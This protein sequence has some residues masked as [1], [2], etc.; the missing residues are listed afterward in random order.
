MQRI[1]NSLFLPP[2]RHRPTHRPRS[3]IASNPCCGTQHGGIFLPPPP[4]ASTFSLHPLFNLLDLGS[5]LL[6]LLHFSALRPFCVCK[7]LVWSRQ[8]EDQKHTLVQ[9]EPGRR[10]GEGECRIHSAYLEER[11]EERLDHRESLGVPSRGN[12][13]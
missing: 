12:G 13:L 10:G 1:N 6:A 3:I 9:L 7:L 4:R 5:A 2:F 11:R 8:K